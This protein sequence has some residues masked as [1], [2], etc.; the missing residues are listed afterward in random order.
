[1]SARDSVAVAA[2]PQKPALALSRLQLLVLLGALSMFAP[3]STDMY[4]P[5]LPSMTHNLSASASAVQLTLTASL[6][7][8]GAGQLL[9]GP[10]SDAYGRRRPVLIGLLGYT[11][12]SVACALAN[13]VWSLSAMRLVQGAAGAAGIVVAR[14]I[15]R[16]LFAGIEA[17]RFFSRLVIVFGLAPIL[18][19]IVGGALLHVTD[20]RGIFVVLACFGA[21][22]GIVCWRVLGE[23]LPAAERQRSGLGTTLRVLGTLV[24]D[25]R[26]MGLAIVYGLSFGALFAYIAGSPFVLENIFGLSPQLFGVVFAVNAGALV[27]TSQLGVRLLSHTGSR[28]LAAL[29]L[30]AGL[31]SA[32]GLLVAV[33][34]HAGLFAVLLC[35]F[36]LMASYGLI[37]PNVT[38]LAMQEHPHVAGSASALMGLAQFGI[39]AAVA[40]LVGLAGTHS[41]V[42]TATVITTMFV[43][44]FAAWVMMVTRGRAHGASREGAT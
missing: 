30:Y 27:A 36:L 32:L 5:A 24:R 34:A 31:V 39:G 4:L 38:A 11:L 9:V 12:T 35:F 20:W 8:L 7:G 3:L 16:D 18:A 19:P 41:A 6:I 33:L 28:R 23:T 44:S 14:A 43:A 22:L 2:T 10:L 42:P 25:R 17:A 13:D 26:F 21:V 29:G 37:S 40:P 15:V 1:M